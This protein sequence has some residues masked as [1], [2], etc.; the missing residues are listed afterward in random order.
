MWTV[1][2]RSQVNPRKRKEYRQTLDMLVKELRH[3]RGC[4]QC[5]YTVESVDPN[6][7]VMILEWDS[8]K[9][10]DDYLNSHLH[11]VLGG[12][13]QTLCDDHEIVIQEEVKSN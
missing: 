7:Y 9:A 4:I 12:A 3:Y 2:I 10:V 13:I 5:R 8:R 6:I 1:N 11:K